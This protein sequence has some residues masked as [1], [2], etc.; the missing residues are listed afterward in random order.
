[1]IDK[2]YQQS[3]GGSDKNFVNFIKI[4]SQDLTDDA[5]D[6]LE[7]LA[8]RIAQNMYLY[9]GNINTAK[10]DYMQLVAMLIKK[11]VIFEKYKDIEPDP[12]NY[13]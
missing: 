10:S 4:N 1:M 11:G 5:L 2:Y 9:P 7:Y 12:E 8:K 3:L 13:D 6:D